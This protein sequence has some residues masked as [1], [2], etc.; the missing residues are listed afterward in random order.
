MGLLK[1][2]TKCKIKKPSTAEY[3]PLNKNVKCGLDSWCRKCRTNYKK[4]KSRAKQYNVSEEL[5][6][7]FYSSPCVICGKKSGKKVIDH[8]HTTGAVRGSLCQ[9]CNLGLG[10]FKD[11]PERLLYAAAYLL[12]LDNWAEFEKYV[13]DCS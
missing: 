3:Y 5:L 11:D 4:T 7:D 1:T 13:K 9:H 6:Q 10:Q 12:R 2:C 8:C